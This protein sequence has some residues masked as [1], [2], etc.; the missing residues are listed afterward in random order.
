MP[1]TMP[2]STDDYTL[3]IHPACAQRLLAGR[4]VH[5]AGLGGMTDC[6]WYAAWLGSAIVP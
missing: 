6:R 4:K 5:P 1:E 3:V 2:T